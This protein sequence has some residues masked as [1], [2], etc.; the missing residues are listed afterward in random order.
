MLLDGDQDGKS[1]KKEKDG[2]SK[3]T[4]LEKL[5]ESKITFKGTAKAVSLAQRLSPKSQRR[6][7]K[8]SSSTSQLKVNSVNY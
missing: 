4:S 2:K 8:I 3:A 1:G 7:E 6:K 5:K